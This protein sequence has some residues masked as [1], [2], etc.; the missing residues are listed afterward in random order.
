MS[1][2]RPPMMFVCNWSGSGMQVHRQESHES[3]ASAG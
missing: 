2:G 3:R 1:A